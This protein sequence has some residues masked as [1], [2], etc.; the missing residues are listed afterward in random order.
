MALTNS[1]RSR[2]YPVQGNLSFVYEDNKFKISS[3]TI[4]AIE[5]I[6][7][8]TYG[9]SHGIDGLGN[10]VVKLF[11]LDD[12]NGNEALIYPTV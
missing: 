9:S 8:T 1:D 11:N 7:V 10:T 12:Y 2:F 6:S 3:T 4:S 5:H